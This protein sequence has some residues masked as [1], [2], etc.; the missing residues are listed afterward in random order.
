MS[1]APTLHRQAMQTLDEANVARMSG[2]DA[3]ARQLN[4]AAFALEKQAAE[5]LADAPQHEP[6]RAILYHSAALLALDCSEPREAERLIAA[7]LSGNPPA[8]LKEQLCAM[9]DKITRP[10]AAS[11]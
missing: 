4:R 10:L 2:K 3:Q 11:A 6:T 1:Q 5:L 7:G 9:R 8:A